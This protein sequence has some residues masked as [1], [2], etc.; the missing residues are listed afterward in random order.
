VSVLLL[1]L[2]GQ[3]NFF[4]FIRSDA[5]V[6][7]EAHEKKIQELMRGALKVMTERRRK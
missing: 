1:R 2:S 4:I 6:V 7:K 3:A 5:S